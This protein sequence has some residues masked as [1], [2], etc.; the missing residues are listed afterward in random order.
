MKYNAQC[1]FLFYYCI[2]NLFF[3]KGKGI[4]T[5]HSWGLVY[6]YFVLFVLLFFLC[7]HYAGY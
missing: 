5:L 6:M 1:F 2:L 4:K 7:P 3:F